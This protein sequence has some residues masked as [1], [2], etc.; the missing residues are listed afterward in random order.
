MSIQSLRLFQLSSAALPTGAYAFSQGLETATDEG[1]LTHFDE[2][3]E[4]L[5]LQLKHTLGLGDLPLLI[6][7]MK[8]F[9]NSDVA[10]Q[11]HWNQMAL[12]LRETHEMRLTDTATATALMRLLANLKGTSIIHEFTIKS[13]MSF[14]SAFALAASQWNIS[15]DDGCL[16]YVW[17]WLENQVAGATKLVPLGQTQS[18]QLLEKLQPLAI[19]AIQLAHQCADDDIGSSL[20]ALAIASCWHENQY[21]RLFRS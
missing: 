2:V 14:I 7:M 16:G 9:E 17:S 4:W 20:P 1:W 19:D 6:R 12:A 18:Q 21:S 13:D 5:A 10:Q 3:F 11:T 15:V 8:A